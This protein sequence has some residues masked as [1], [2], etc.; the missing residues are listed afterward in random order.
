MAFFR[1]SIG[2]GGGGSGWTLV[3]AVSLVPGGVGTFTI[4]QSLTVGKTY[5]IFTTNSGGSTST[6][7]AVTAITISSGASNLTELNKVNGYYGSSTAYSSM[8]HYSFIATA[9]T[10]SFSKNAAPRR[11]GYMLFVE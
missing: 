5:H 10:V 7:D 6:A 8:I 2:G 11:L 3:E 4:G 1:A 9:Q